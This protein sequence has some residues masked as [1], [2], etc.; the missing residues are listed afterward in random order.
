MQCHGFHR[1]APN[2]LDLADLAEFNLGDFNHPNRRER[3][4]QAAQPCE[5]SK[6][7]LVKHER[8]PEA[9]ENLRWR[10]WQA[11]Q[12]H[13]TARTASVHA[14]A[15]RSGLL[16]TTFWLSSTISFTA[17]S[18]S[19]PAPADRS[20]RPLH[21]CPPPRKTRRARSPSMVFPWLLV[22]A[23]RSWRGRSPRRRAV[24]VVAQSLIQSP[25]HSPAA[26]RHILLCQACF[27]RERARVHASTPNA[28]L[29]PSISRC[30]HTRGKGMGEGWRRMDSRVRSSRVRVSGPCTLISRQ[31]G[32]G[33]GTCGGDLRVLKGRLAVSF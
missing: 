32:E 24:T 8:R 12:A 23:Q 7:K 16:N 15:A 10:I 6:K 22:T 25:C 19:L 21:H 28:A 30:S 29:A 5:Q 3:A 27:V 14:H 9:P 1:H 4:R 18:P 2:I 26:R 17:T 31:R 13:A 20:R 11:V 33:K